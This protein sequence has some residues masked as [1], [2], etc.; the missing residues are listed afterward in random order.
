MHARV[1]RKTAHAHV[2]LLGV[3]LGS[4]PFRV[5]CLS[6]LRFLPALVRL[7]L[8]VVFVTAVSSFLA[9]LGAS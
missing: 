8:V 1:R 7:E 3:H 5:L 6:F 2:T 4:L 9:L